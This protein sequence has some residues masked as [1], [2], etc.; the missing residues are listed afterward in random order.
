MRNM[1]LDRLPAPHQ[2]ILVGVERQPWG[3][4]V[5]YLADSLDALLVAGC[6]TPAIHAL[7]QDLKRNR[8]KTRDEDG[9]RFFRRRR[10]LKV[11]PGRV[12][13][14][15][16]TRC[17][18]KALAL[19]GVSKYLSSGRSRQVGPS[20]GAIVPDAHARARTGS[21]TP[22]EEEDATAAQLRERQVG[23]SHRRIRWAVFANVIFPDW[24]SM[25][26]EMRAA[27]T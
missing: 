22:D 17:E 14:E 25:R 4:I 20:A 11:A 13:I 23:P 1:N 27:G 2:T 19:P 8:G 18:A 5:A 9:D 16:W 6:I 26:M 7:A 10:P 24:A 21:E 3:Y 12:E 15:R